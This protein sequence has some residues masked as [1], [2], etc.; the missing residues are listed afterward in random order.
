MYD[1][2]SFGDGAVAAPSKMNI[3][4]QL[5]AVIESTGKWCRITGTVQLAVM[6]VFMVFALLT[7]ACGTLASTSAGA[8]AMG[9]TMAASAIMLA[10]LAAGLWQA[11]RLQTAGEQLKLLALESDADY[12]EFAFKRLKTVFVIDVVIGALMVFKAL[13]AWGGF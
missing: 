5:E 13:Q 7:A 8:G 10:A 1:E 3:D 2:P 11:L 9:T 12:L 4:P 6:G